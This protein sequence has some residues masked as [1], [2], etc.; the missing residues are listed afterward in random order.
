MASEIEWRGKPTEVNSIFV[1]LPFPSWWLAITDIAVFGDY[2]ILGYILS[3]QFPSLAMKKIYA[4][5]CSIRKIHNIRIYLFIQ[6]FIIQTCLLTNA[7]IFSEINF[8]RI[9]VEVKKLKKK[10][11][12]AKKRET[13]FPRA[14]QTKQ[15]AVEV[16]SKK[17]KTQLISVRYWGKKWISS[18]RSTRKLMDGGIYTLFQWQ[19]RKHCTYVT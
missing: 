16:A 3:G 6:K 8:T 14:R 17:R 9:Y 18:P 19:R 2:L 12:Y 13:T 5:M 4:K 10:K 11:N 15:L 1:L 7:Y